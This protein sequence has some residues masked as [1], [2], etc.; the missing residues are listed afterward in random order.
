MGAGERPEPVLGAAAEAILISD[1][2]IF[3][4]CSL[5]ILALLLD[6]SYPPQSFKTWPVNVGG[7]GQMPKRKSTG[8]MIYKKLIKKQGAPN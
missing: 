6:R 2:L 1:A 7:P 5:P 4:F 3:P 8:D